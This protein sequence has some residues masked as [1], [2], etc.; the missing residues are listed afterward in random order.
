MGKYKQSI[1]QMTSRTTDTINIFLNTD[2]NYI[3]PAY[4][5]IYSLMY[6]YRGKAPVNIHILTPGDIS[7]HN[8]LFLKS[9]IEK[10]RIFE[11]FIIDMRDAYREV[12][13]KSCFT[14]TIL[15]RL[16]IP[17]ICEQLNLK[18]DKCIYLD[19]DIVVEGDITELYNVDADWDEYYCAGVRDCLT[20][21]RA[22]WFLK[23]KDLLGIPSMDRYINAGVLLINLKQI[24]EDS[25]LHRL[26]E[27]GYREDFL[28]YDQDAIN[29]VCYEGIK[30][31]PLKYDVMPQVFF[32]NN[33][34]IYSNYGRENVLDAK[35]SPVV[36]HYMDKYKPWSH[37]RLYLARHWWRYV[38]MQDEEIM[39]EYITPFIEPYKVPLSTTVKDSL[40]SVLIH[41]GAYNHFKK[42]KHLLNKR[43]PKK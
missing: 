37:R 39:R 2:N 20:I 23:H 12:V 30:L 16:M 42:I 8:Q 13:M 25:L 28:F 41:I 22:E 15:Y 17:R 11:I 10:N 21:T 4:I 27:A 43:T 19:T 32:H 33:S 14:N 3:V 38:K 5:T 9:L 7:P 24:K 34:E 31:I 40:L 6:N 26:E 18:T 36:I 29:S 35:K 1:L